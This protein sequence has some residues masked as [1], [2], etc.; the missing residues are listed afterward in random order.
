MHC[1]IEMRESKN[2]CANNF[3]QET[4]QIS[5]LPLF[6]PRFKNLKSKTHL[7]MK[8]EVKNALKTVASINQ[9]TLT[10]KIEKGCHENICSLTTNHIAKRV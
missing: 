3:L 2:K 8:V 7:S 9:T 5:T 10:T 6:N 1:E 4:F